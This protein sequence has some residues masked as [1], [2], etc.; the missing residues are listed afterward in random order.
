MMPL[1]KTWFP[2]VTARSK[3]AV[4]ELS[5]TGAPAVVLAPFRKAAPDSRRPSVGRPRN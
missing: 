3:L 5:N 4:A 2:D 1:V